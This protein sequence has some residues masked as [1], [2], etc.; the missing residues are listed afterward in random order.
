[1]VPDLLPRERIGAGI[2]LSYA[3]FHGST[4]VGPAVAGLLAGAVGVTGCYALVLIAFALS[5][6]GLR[7]LPRTPKRESGAG[8]GPLSGL[9]AIR[10]RPPLRG[11][12][13]TDL[14]AMLLAMPV[15][16][17]PALNEA[18]FGG[19]PETLGLFLSAL[20]AGGIVATVLSGAVARH[21]RP[22]AVQLI[23]AAA[24]GLALA[25]AGLAANG[26]A[27][28]VFIAAAGAADTVAAMTRAT[29][30]QLSCPPEVRGRVVAAEQVVGIAAP[31]LGNFRA[32]TLGAAMPPGLAMALGGGACII[33]VAAIAWSHPGL[34]RFRATDPT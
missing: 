23:A 28:I 19:A 30:V 22:G 7:A 14:A 27:T 12:L 10:A 20:A 34:V 25:G 15:S 5:F 8:D 13:L 17:F 26:W 3:S 16:L 6:H 11:T 32:G 29:I 2:A 1:M 31:Q 18:R 9:R 4:L 33:A 21:P 24:W